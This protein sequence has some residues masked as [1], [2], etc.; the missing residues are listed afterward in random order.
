VV[1]RELVVFRGFLCILWYF[2]DILVFL[3]CFCGI[4]L[5]FRRIFGC[6]LWDCWCLGLV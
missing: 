6:F 3:G 1:F 2:G 5:V 4:L